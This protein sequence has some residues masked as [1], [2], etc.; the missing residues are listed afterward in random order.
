MGYP[1]NKRYIDQIREH[2]QECKDIEKAYYVLRSKYIKDHEGYSDPI[3]LSIGESF[4]I[5]GE[6]FELASETVDSITDVHHFMWD[7]LE[8]LLTPVKGQDEEP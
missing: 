7:I 2:K 5:L 1:Y 4:A 3:D 6:A 8:E